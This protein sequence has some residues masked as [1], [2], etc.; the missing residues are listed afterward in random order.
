M[1]DR[2][3]TEN[4]IYNSIFDRLLDEQ[5]DQGYFVHCPLIFVTDEQVYETDIPNIIG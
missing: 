3:Q 4:Y 5:L 2:V 1:L